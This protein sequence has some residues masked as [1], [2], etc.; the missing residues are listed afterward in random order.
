MRVAHELLQVEHVFAAHDRHR[1]RVAAAGRLREDRALFV[2]VG[3]VDADVQQETVE[4]RFGQRIGAGLLDRILRRQH[5]ERRR[6]RVRRAG[7]AD[8]ALLH[9]FEQRRLRLR[10][11]AVDLVGEQQVRE[12]RAALELEVALAGAVVFFEDLGADDVARHQV[13][14]ELDA[15]EIER[16]RLAERAHEQRLAESRHAFEQAVAAGERPISSC[17]TTSR[18]PTIT[19]AIASRSAASLSS[20]VATICSLMAWFIHCSDALRRGATSVRHPGES[21]I[22]LLSVQIRWIPAFAGTTV[23]DHDVNAYTTTLTANFVLSSASQRLL[24]QS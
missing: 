11:R 20:C 23:I 17:S 1:A 22:H 21:R 6:Q 13:G 16:E 2:F 4:L 14:R 10:R 9:R 12:H 8:R 5:E 18:W 7:V 3:I 24:R 19:R 15:A